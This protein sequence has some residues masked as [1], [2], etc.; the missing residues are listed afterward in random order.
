[1][2]Q[3]DIIIEIRKICGSVKKMPV[4][5]WHFVF[6]NRHIF[7]STNDKDGG[8]LRFCV[9]HIANVGDFDL[10]RVNEALNDTNRNVKYVKAVRLDCGSVAINYDH[11]ASLDETA[12]SIV[13]QIRRTLD[14]GS[15]YL[16]RQL[17]RYF[18]LR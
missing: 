3:E 13:K 2:R 8:M 10:E 6:N 5:G 14:F 15:P 17:E 18:P 4:V 7:F 16:V 11:R 9:P 1:M 12:E